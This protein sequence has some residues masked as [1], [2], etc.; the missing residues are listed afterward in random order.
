LA[1]IG[2]GTKETESFLAGSRVRRSEAIGRAAAKA[3]TKLQ[4]ATCLGDLRNPPSN[5][6][7]ALGGDRTGEYSIRINIQYRVCFR[8]VLQHPVPEDVDPLFAPG[9]ADDVEIVDYH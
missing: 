5:H 7:E 3:L 2:C 4:I 1:I 6:L 8:W 9:D